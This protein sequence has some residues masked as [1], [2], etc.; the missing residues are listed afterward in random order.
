MTPPPDPTAVFHEQLL[1]AL[2]KIHT[3]LSEIASTLKALVTHYECRH[4]TDRLAKGPLVE[5]EM[6]DDDDLK[7]L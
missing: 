6:F 4:L 3:D 2:T 1:H 7:G 5:E